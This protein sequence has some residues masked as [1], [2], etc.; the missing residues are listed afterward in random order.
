M[1]K[2]HDIEQINKVFYPFNLSV[3]EVIE[4]LRINQY[5]VKLPL[6]GN[7]NKYLKLEK[8]LM[9]ALNDNSI[10]VFQEG[11]YLVIQKQSNT[12]RILKMNECFYTSMYGF[13]NSFPLVLGKDIQGNTIRTSLVKAPHILVAGCTGSGKTQLLHSFIASILLAGQT[14]NLI[15]I[16]P[17]V[18]EFYVYKDVPSVTFIS[19]V[20]TAIAKLNWLVTEM[21]N[22]YAEMATL[23]ITDIDDT[24]YT[25]V[26]CVID[27]F[28]DLIM[29]NRQIEQSIVLL[30]QKARAAGI[31]L[32]IGTQYPKVDVITGLIKANI[33]TRV[34]LKVN[35]TT[36]SRVAI[37]CCGGEKLIGHGDLLFKGNGMYE[38][39]NIQ[40]P[41]ISQEDKLSVVK[42]ASTKFEGKCDAFH[43]NPTPEYQPNIPSFT[44]PV[45]FGNIG[46]K[47]PEQQKKHLGLFGTIR[48]LWNASPYFIIE[49]KEK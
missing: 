8:N 28:A 27:E 41:F 6:E 15:L 7:L 37:D 38:P 35:S 13:N 17:K 22:R 30:A 49:E 12:N 3:S 46:K 48:A 32:I 31:H 10:K 14:A 29:S 34:C 44:P 20:N 5:K 4:G 40:A 9:A 43:D 24:K 19:D 25:R 11:S 42:Y 23:G 39:I 45:D 36:E 47:E 33:P 2:E 16:D 18:T 1:T 26:I 21:N